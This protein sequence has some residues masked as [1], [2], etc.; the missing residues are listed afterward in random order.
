MEKEL[1]NEEKSLLLALCLGDGCLRKPNPRGGNVQF[2]CAHS[3]KQEEYLTWKRDLV[4]KIF[5]GNKPP[6]IGYKEIKLKGY[7]TTYHAC[8]FCK[9][10]P[11]FTYLRKLLYPDGVKVMTREILDKLTPQGIAIWYMD[12]GSFYK[13]DNADGTKSICF[14]LR[15]STDCFSKEENEI[16]VDYF[17][18]VWGINFYVFLGHKDRKNYNWIIRANK[19]AAIKFIDLVKPY[20]IP[21]MEYKIE[22]KSINNFQE[23][24]ASENS[25]EDIV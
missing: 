13:K 22:Y 14:D 23:C 11:Y 4:Y 8:R 9:T 2:E 25:D 17:K 18:E 10:H 16:I 3:T 24:E 5:G 7:D 20:I 21:S 6:K 19:E 12:D 15:I 1:T